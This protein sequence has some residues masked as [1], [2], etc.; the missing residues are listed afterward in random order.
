MLTPFS[1]PM[2]NSEEL[3]RPKPMALSQRQPSGQYYAGGF[4]SYAN[5]LMPSMS[6]YFLLWSC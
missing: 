3:T 1:M 4:L 5:G 2:T 6:R